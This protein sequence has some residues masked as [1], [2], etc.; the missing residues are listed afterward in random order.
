MDAGHLLSWS[1]E[2]GV[3]KGT[4]YDYQSMGKALGVLFGPLKARRKY[5]LQTASP[6]E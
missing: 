3:S 4:T 6:P 1:E 2:E 5:H